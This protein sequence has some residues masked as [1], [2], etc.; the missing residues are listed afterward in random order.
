MTFNDLFNE[1]TVFMPSCD[2]L[3]LC[4]GVYSLLL[5]RIQ[6]KGCHIW[7]KVTKKTMASSWEL[8]LVLLLTLRR[9]NWYVVGCP[10]E[11]P[12]VNDQWGT[13]VFGQNLTRNWILPST[14][15]VT[16][17]A[18]AP[19]I[20]ELGPWARGAQLS[21]TQIPDPQKLWDNKCLLF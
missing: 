5:N 15:W 13:E 19:S 7:D 2:P 4:I 6:Q 16:S 11:R 14:T 12:L 10:I 20:W 3:P 9:D 17:E 1:S 21:S 8:P 18:D